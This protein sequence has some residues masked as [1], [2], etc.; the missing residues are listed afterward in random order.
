MTPLESESL[1]SGWK[2]TACLSVHA[3]SD[4]MVR[5]CAPVRSG[6]P[7]GSRETTGPHFYEANWE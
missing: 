1:S 4:I 5:E 7:K 2:D 6:S 3:S